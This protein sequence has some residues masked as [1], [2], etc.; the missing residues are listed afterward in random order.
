[1]TGSPG[2]T[3]R[4]PPIRDRI[5]AL[6]R[7]YVPILA[8]LPA[9]P[10]AALRPDL[11]AGLTSWGVMVPVALAYA[12]L[13]GVPPQL[14]LATAF[15]ALA[16]Y[17]V[18]A[19]SRHVKVTASSTMAIM[20][21][22][23]VA[24]IASGDPT[25]FPAE[26]AALAILVGLLLLAG[27][28]ARLGF[29]SDFLSKP[30]ISGFIFGVAITIVVGQIPR[31][32]GIPSG[33]G[34]VPEEIAG[35]L[36]GLG[37]TDPVTLAVGLAALGLILVLRTISPRIP[38]ALVALVLGI[39]AAKALDLNVY[40]VS[41]VGEIATGVGRPGIPDVPLAALPALL[42]GA[43]GILFVA[44]GETV[45][46]G[47]AFADRYR[48]EVDPDQE[49]IALGAANLA[50]G[51][52]GGFAVD[53][54]LSQTATAETAGTRT[55]LSSL[56]TSA[57]ILATALVL[58][59]LFSDLPNAVLGAIVI[60]AA[61]GLMEWREL[62]RYW[63]WQRTDFVVAVTALGGVVVFGV[64]TGLVVA[65]LLSVL[66]LLYRA[67][68]PYVA[69]LGALPGPERTFGDL[70][71]HPHAE[72]VRGIV[73]VR[74]DAPLY[75]FNANVAH[76]Q[77]LRLVDAPEPRPR[78]AVIDL[79]ATGD[80]DVTTADMVAGLVRDM[81]ERAVELAFA[82]VRGSVRDRLRRTGLMEA[83]GEG[84][85]YVSVGAAV[86]GLERELALAAQAPGAGPGTG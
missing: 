1:M 61:L 50:S 56:V 73:I 27:G 67:S 81:R 34:S 20:S 66:L 18:F 39:V 48:Y 8:W 57:L 59:P 37:E 25:L 63:A 70:A 17:A 38:G 43:A 22:T 42:L 16:A 79:A 54:S 75:F 28:I 4:R 24:D 86:D 29:I 78:A 19:T 26:T 6:A 44:V 3:P 62:L 7:H 31:I 5:P 49:L 60:A 41:L 82:Q 47:R 33:S 23:I 21:A 71:R 35:I 77:I 32:L 12:G 13:A 65:V 84:R 30:V 14:G 83:V 36:H 45:G 46:T 15:A 58:A 53:A 2:E 76:L 10:R 85:I 69:A 51:M 68:R 72:P 55:Q 11:V 40:G 9:Y 74:V 64:L 80:L 52:F